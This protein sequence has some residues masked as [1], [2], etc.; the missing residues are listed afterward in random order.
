MARGGL[1]AHPRAPL[2]MR[3]SALRPGSVSECGALWLG[4]GLAA[5]PSV[6]VGVGELTPT[7]RLRDPL[8]PRSRRSVPATRPKPAVP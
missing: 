4:G 5:T 8:R 7:S 6:M 3:A 2:T 1:R